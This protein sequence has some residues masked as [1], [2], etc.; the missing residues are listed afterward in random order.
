MNREALVGDVLD[1]MDA[2]LVS[3]ACHLHE[4]LPTGSVTVSADVVVA[5]SGLTD[6]T[7]NIIAGARFAVPAAEGPEEDRR[8][9]DVLA[10]LRATGRPF[11][12]WTGPR[13]KPS[14]LG[15]R[16]SALGCVRSE[17]ER[18]MTA[19]LD[20]VPRPTPVSELCVQRVTTRSQL[21]DYA[22]VMAANWS[23]PS[24][25]V[26]RFFEDTA[27]DILDERSRSSF[28]VG[29]AN[30]QPVA[31]AE[32]HFAA[33]VAGLYGVVTLETARRRGFG[34][35]VTLAALDIARERGARTAVLQAS[36]DGAQLYRNVG[37]EDV[38]TYAE[39]S[40]GSG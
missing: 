20:V 22:A 7:F 24:T 16:L 29:Y 33:D 8:L 11:S 39:Y 40:I 26:I 19:D 3:H 37:F 31:G 14:D 36:S 6:D 10:W 4:H 27:D 35:A 5:D 12:W 2:N 34:S 17:E 38:G 13:D 18:A 15:A 32:V 1:A 30:S 28:V 25:A 23:P 21:A 9:L